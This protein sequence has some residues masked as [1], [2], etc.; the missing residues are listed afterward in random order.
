MKNSNKLI[1]LTGAMGSGKSTVLNIFH[2]L[3]CTTLDADD[4]CH[5]L[6]E[7]DNYVISQ[8]VSRWGTN[9]LNENNKLDRKKIAKIVFESKKELDWLN[10]L[11]HN[12]V[13]KKAKE[14]IADR[15][16]I[17]IFD[18]PLLFEANW[19]IHFDKTITVW[20]TRELQFKRLKDKKWTAQE[21]ASRIKF[22]MSADEKLER[23]DFGIINI[24]SME[25]LIKQCKLILLEI[26]R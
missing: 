8:I 4:I 23:A 6:Y 18:V 20:T 15:K 17:T 16:N 22:Q 2:T 13:L 25:L 3:G 21:I 26:T 7:N 12:L 9:L 11:L 5:D 1:G 19:Q 10:N 24:G 14:S